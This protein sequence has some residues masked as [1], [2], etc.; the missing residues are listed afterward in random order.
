MSLVYEAGM[1][2]VR[3]LERDPKAGRTFVEAAARAAEG[4]LRGRAA[5][6]AEVERVAELIATAALTTIYVPAKR[7]ERGAIRHLGTQ[8]GVSAAQEILNGRRD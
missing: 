7:P 1:V 3:R 4:E 6:S 2:M 8:A 5:T